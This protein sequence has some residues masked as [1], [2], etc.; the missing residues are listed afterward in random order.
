MRGG[1]EGGGLE[2]AAPPVGLLPRRLGRAAALGA[3]LP[4]LLLCL[5]FPCLSWTPRRARAPAAHWP[6]CP[7]PGGSHQVEG[8]PSGARRR[9]PPGGTCS[10]SLAFYVQPFTLP[11][12]PPPGRA[13]SAAGAPAPPE[14]RPSPPSAAPPPAL[15]ARPPLPV[16]ASTTSRRGQSQR[17]RG[18]PPTTATCG[19]STPRRPAQAA[20]TDSPPQKQS[21][22]DNENNGRTEAAVH[23]TMAERAASAAAVRADADGGRV[24]ASLAGTPD[25]GGRDVAKGTG[26]KGRGSTSWACG[27]TQSAGDC[28]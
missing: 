5:C 8:A 6:G 24:P 2:E 20:T 11:R 13:R 9:A 17:R 18:G 19:G 14:R 23:V 27:G 7:R 21:R 26:A 3:P 1:G 25:P 12:R 15:P 28:L 10:R 4:T 16:A 22:M